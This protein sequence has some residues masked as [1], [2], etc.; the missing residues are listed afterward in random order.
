MTATMTTGAPPEVRWSDYGCINCLWRGVECENEQNYEP[1]TA[2]D[3][4]AGCVSY[5][6]CD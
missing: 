3:G 4:Q 1:A 2:H 5:V 6:Y